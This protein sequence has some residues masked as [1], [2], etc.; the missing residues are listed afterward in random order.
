[1]QSVTLPLQGFLNAIV[2]GWTRE[3]FVNALDLGQHVVQSSMPD[4]PCDDS[5]SS[6]F[7]MSLTASYTSVDNASS[8]GTLRS[9]QGTLRST[10]S[11]LR[12]THSTHIHTMHHSTN[13]MS[14]S[15]GSYCV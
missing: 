10:Q 6:D 14:D 12:S 13:R 11:T 9:T 15:G 1:M 3:D 7:D 5:D 2:Y 4:E 8:R